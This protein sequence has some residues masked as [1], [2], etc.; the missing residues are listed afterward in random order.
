MWGGSLAQDGILALL[1]A[2]APLHSQET[3]G[4]DTLQYIAL[5]GCFCHSPISLIEQ[6]VSMFF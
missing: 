3:N 5:N 4:F 2:S 6:P 1:L